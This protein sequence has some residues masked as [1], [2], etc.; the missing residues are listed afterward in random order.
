V[1]GLDFLTAARATELQLGSG[2]ILTRDSTA[3]GQGQRAAP[4]QAVIGRVVGCRSPLIACRELADLADRAAAHLDREDRRQRREE[5]KVAGSYVFLGHGRSLLWMELKGFVEDRLGLRVD[6]FNR[7]PV[8][9]VTNVERLVQM[10]DDAALALL[11]LTA[12]DERVD[13]SVVARQNVVHEAGLFQGRLGF[14][15]AIVVIEDGCGGFSNIE[16]LGEIRFPKGEI[17]AAFEEV[18][19]VLEREGLV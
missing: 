12:E 5:R 10:L 18:R 2:Q 3:S 15:R 14:T 19:Q 7:V 17:K 11:V 13:G 6:E 1:E 4:H 16:G 9:G 8:A